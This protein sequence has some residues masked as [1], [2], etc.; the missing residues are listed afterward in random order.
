M[1]NA[2]GS[3]SVEARRAAQARDW[4][5]ALELLKRAAEAGTLGAEDLE[6]LADAR[7]WTGQQ[8]GIVEA[9]EAA[10][11]VHAEAGDARGVARV[12][13]ALAYAHT[14][15]NEAGPAGAWLE[16]AA[17]VL[18]DLPECADH[19]L[20]AWMR[21]RACGGA[22]RLD[23]HEHHALEALEIARRSGAANVESLAMLD[24]GHLSVARGEPAAGA[25]HLDRATSLALSEDVG[26]LETGI[27]FCG[28][29]WTYRCCG[30]WAL[31]EQWTRTADRW[32]RRE[33][34]EYFPGLCRVHRAEVLRARGR[35]REAEA[36]CLEA[37]RLLEAA[38][39]RWTTI[40][41]AELGEVRRRLGDLGGAMEGFRKALA[42]GWDPQ[43][44]LSL[45]MLAQGDA[46]AAHG[47]IE[48]TLGG[49]LPTWLHEDR[50]S[51]LAARVTIALAVDDE[52]AALAALT[53]LETRAQVGGAQELAAAAQARGELELARGDAAAAAVTLARAK[54]GW[55]EQ[56]TPYE[57]A[58]AGAL[59]G[60]AL[61]ADGDPRGAE[62]ELAAARAGFERIGAALDAERVG[63]LL[64]APTAGERLPQ[65]PAYGSARLAREG[66]VWA[67]TFA[68][69]TVRLKRTRGLD[70]LARLLPHP[71]RDLAALALVA[72]TAVAPA[73]GDAGALLDT[74]AR[75]A[76]RRRLGELAAEVEDA[77]ERG[78]EARQEAAAS[79]LEAL[80]R[81]LAATLGLGGRARRG[82]SPAERARQSVTKALRASIRRIA[83]LHPEL[84][85]HLQASVRTGALCRYAPE[86]PLAWEVVDGAGPEVT[87]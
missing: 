73:G 19:A 60:G 56:A 48:R 59:L 31:A 50:T 6:R 4:P 30:R 81:E 35:L 2:E 37:V 67:L 26:P 27:V 45:L 85:R 53:E 82:P 33:R 25:E 21:G 40:A 41:Y 57:L 11:A 22:G 64:A 29:V 87:S 24:L 52:P 61:A 5:R 71:D 23:A 18:E 78:D 79:E 83:A 72:D 14:D 66:D 62:L 3:P 55:S 68:A 44:G 65:Q 75:E 36:E 43:P 17:R 10:H 32:C 1:G 69:R 13:L 34:I 63:T 8:A 28:A 38:I 70:Y 77:R 42:L 12:A 49:E 39:P 84:G 51:F 16:R 80:R 9:L 86:K 20:L 74:E 76:Y 15:A 46:R 58:T 54:R 47:A 7:R